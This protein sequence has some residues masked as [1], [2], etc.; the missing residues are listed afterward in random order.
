ML[1]AQIS[2]KSAEHYTPA[3]FVEAARY[4]LGDIDLDPASSPVANET[5]RAVRF[6]TAADDGLA[7]P[8]HGRVFVNPP[9]DK[10]GQL[11]KAFWRRSCMHARDPGGVVL[12]VGFNI[13]QLQSLQNGLSPL[14]DGQPCPH[15]F[16]YPRVVPSSRVAW[17]KPGA[18]KNA[19]P[20][21]GNYFCLLGG[22]AA[23]RRRLRER[24]R[25]FGE[26]VPPRPP[27]RPARDLEAEL[28]AA[29]LEQGPVASKIALARRVRARRAD[30]IRALDAL[31]ERG[32]VHLENGEFAVP[33]AW[34]QQARSCQ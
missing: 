18:G 6:Y 33:Q 21:H 28:V 10:R 15:P 32:A 25:E 9:G 5:V 27:Q 16:D 24:F 7:Q 14:D 4:V 2:C 34:E 11:V 13:Q 23:M 22:D 1:S 30:V 26:Y 19:S 12:W 20:P 31:V 3:R 17:V 29:L 8:W